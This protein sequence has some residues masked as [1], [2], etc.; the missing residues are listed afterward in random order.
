ME[1]LSQK[2]KTLTLS[3]RRNAHSMRLVCRPGEQTL[4]WV[5]PCR[6]DRSLGKNHGA[7]PW[8]QYGGQE[9]WRQHLSVQAGSGG[10]P[11]SIAAACG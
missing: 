8:V 11:C 10:H 7:P 6:W 9:S 1:F 4:V 3:S 5:W 2:W